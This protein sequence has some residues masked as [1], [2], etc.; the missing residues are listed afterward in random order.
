MLSAI[1]FFI[2]GF[3]FLLLGAKLAIKSAAGLARAYGISNLIIGSTI[4]AF[5]TS[6]PELIVGIF[7]GIQEKGDLALGNVLGACFANILLI[8]GVVSLVKPLRTKDDKEV[9]QSFLFFLIA[10]AAVAVL[11]G[12]FLELADGGLARGDGLILLL[13]FFLFLWLLSW[14]KKEISRSAEEAKENKKKAPLFS[15]LFKILA[16]LSLLALGGHLAVEG[17]AKL[18][19]LLGVSEY[20][21]G[22]TVISLGTTLPELFTALVAVW[23][24]KT[25]IALGSAV[26]SCVFN[27]CLVLGVSASIRPL[28]SE[29]FFGFDLIILALAVLL[30]L[31]LLFYGKKNILTRKKGAVLL[32]FYFLYLLFLIY[33]Q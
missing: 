10:V 13:I 24:K 28:S 32:A 27:L 18:A 30:L 12:D 3:V 19:A 23:Q 15:L 21:I 26:G 25:E 17:G 2:S 6:A 16:G 14:E 22:L 9:K 7:S 29:R 1:I 20:I 5:G 11:A 31:F 33:R 8:L 4:I